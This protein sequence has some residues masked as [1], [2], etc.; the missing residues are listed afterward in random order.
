LFFFSI[1]STKR[2]SEE[3]SLQKTKKQKTTVFGSTTKPTN[4]TKRTSEEVSLQ[5]TKKQKT[6]K[7]PSKS[8]FVLSFF[9]FFSL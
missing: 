5:K 8:K 4:L 1:G 6:T 3:V 9:S 2:T 7:V